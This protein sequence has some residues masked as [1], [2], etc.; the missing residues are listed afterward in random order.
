MQILS[1]GFNDCTE[2]A[3]QTG[4]VVAYPVRQGSM[5]WMELG[6]VIERTF[7]SDGRP[8]IRL[9]KSDGRRNVMVSNLRN[10]VIVNCDLDRDEFDGTEE[11]SLC[12]KENCNSC[13]DAMIEEEEELDRLQDVEDSR[14]S[15]YPKDTFLLSELAEEDSPSDADGTMNV[16]GSIR[17]NNCYVTIINL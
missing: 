16:E 8:A 2:R 10:C 5:M 3:I 14:T 1:T 6:T 4:D 7:N 12:E 9:S 13:A 11:C 17:L 15:Q